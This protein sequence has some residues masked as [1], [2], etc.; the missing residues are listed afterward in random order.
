MK[1]TTWINDSATLSNPPPGS[2]NVLVGKK[3]EGP[4]TEGWQLEIQPT[5]FKRNG[6][7]KV[8]GRIEG[9]WLATKVETLDQLLVALFGFTAS[10]VE[11]LTAL[12]NHLKETTAGRNVFLIP[13]EVIGEVQNAHTQQG[14]LIVRTAGVGFMDLEVR[15][16]DGA[17][18]HVFV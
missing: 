2:I 3:V 9:K 13:T 11:E 8:R 4:S 7:G 5:A 18:A 17:F 12:G 1:I 6:H 16:I 15:G 10:V 14:N